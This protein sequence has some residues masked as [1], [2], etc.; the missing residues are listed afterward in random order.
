VI[1]SLHLLVRRLLDARG[2]PVVIALDGPS[3]AGKSTVAAALAAVMP[4]A[5]VPSDD[6]FPFEITAAEWNERSPEER[7]AQAIDCRRLRRLALEP[8]R[9]NHP[10]T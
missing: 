4:A 3:G 9:A 10:A 5:V 1:D 6:F 2:A 7:A 8:L